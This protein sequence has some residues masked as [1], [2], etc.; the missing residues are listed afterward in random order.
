MANFDPLYARL[1]KKS[2]AARNLAKKGARGEIPG[3][4]GIEVPPRRSLF[5]CLFGTR[6]N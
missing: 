1:A 3:V 6:G 4:D 5:S 2:R